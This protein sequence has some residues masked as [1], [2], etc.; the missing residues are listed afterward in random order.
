[1]LFEIEGKVR[2]KERRKSHLSRMN[3]VVK[4]KKKSLITSAVDSIR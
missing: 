2:G 4:V 3:Q 1:M